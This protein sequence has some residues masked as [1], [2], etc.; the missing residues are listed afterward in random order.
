VAANASN[1]D[2]TVLG[3]PTPSGQSIEFTLWVNGAATPLTCA[4]NT[5]GAHTC[6]DTTDKASLPAGATVSLS[7][8]Y[9]HQGEPTP[10]ANLPRVIFGYEVG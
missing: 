5:A 6:S 7:V 3:S 1:L 10:S 9:N 8:F 4:V 2:V